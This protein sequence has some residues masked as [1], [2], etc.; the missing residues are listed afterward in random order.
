MT[1]SCCFLAGDACF[2]PVAM[3][4]RDLREQVIERLNEKYPG[5][6]DAAGIKMPTENW[7]AYQFSPK[8]HLHAASLDY[9]G[10]LQ[11]KHKVQ[12]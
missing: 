3:S 5:G 9:T 4:V 12:A 6:L 2:L 11:I 8:H 10:A 1:C 7:T